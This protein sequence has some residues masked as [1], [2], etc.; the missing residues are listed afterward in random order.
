MGH[1]GG[2]CILLVAV[3]GLPMNSGWSESE[4]GIICVMPSIV[5]AFGS[6]VVVMICDKKLKSCNNNIYVLITITL[7]LFFTHSPN[8]KCLNTLVKFFFK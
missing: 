1:V 5:M 2:C 6:D 7:I 4:W 8:Q 3:V